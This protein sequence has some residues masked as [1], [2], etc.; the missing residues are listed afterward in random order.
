MALH[1]Q[2]IMW[3]HKLKNTCN[4]NQY[5]VPEVGKKTTKK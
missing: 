5:A 4:I 1:T 2:L 3:C